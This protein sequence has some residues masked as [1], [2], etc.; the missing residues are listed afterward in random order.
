MNWHAITSHN[1]MKKFPK[2]SIDRNIFSWALEAGI[3][4][5]E[6][7][8]S[9]DYVER[10][11]KIVSGK[12][13][14]ELCGGHGLVGLILAYKKIA[15]SVHLVDK[16]NTRGHQRLETYFNVWTKATFDQMD[17]ET[18]LRE[19]NP[20]HYDV[21]VG[22]HLCGGLSDIA[23]DF[24]L[25]NNLEVVMTPCCFNLLRGNPVKQV[26]GAFAHLGNRAMQDAV[27][28][29]RASRIWQKGYNLTVKYLNEAISPMNTILVGTK[30]GI[31]NA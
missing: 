9:F 25:H 19:C 23:I 1:F 24:A 21:V 26:T 4:D 14:L 2:H 7:Q 27:N 17:L 15:P 11:R 6:I 5:K 3:K 30:K 20:A 16:N 29:L 13:V 22:M 18:F 31:L 10:I 8:E 12:R 28:V